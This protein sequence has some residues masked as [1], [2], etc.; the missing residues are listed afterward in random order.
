MTL[1]IKDLVF[2]TSNTTGTGTYNLAGPTTGFRSFAVCGNGAKVPYIASNSAGAYEIGIG[3]VSVGTPNLL[4]R[5]TILA[6]SNS[7]AAVNWGAA[8][9]IRLAPLAGINMVKDENLNFT[10][11]LGAAGGLANAHTVTLNPAPLAYSDGMMIAYRATIANTAAMTVN[12]NG[13]GAKALKVNGVDPV[14]GQIAIGTLIVGIYKAS[15]NTFE[16]INS[17]GVAYLPLSGGNLSGAIN[18]SISTI[19]SAATPDIWTG[20]GNVIN[21]TGAVTAT[22]F[23]NAPQ[24][25]ARRTLVCADACTFNNGANMIINGGAN[26]TA[27]AGDIVNVIAVTTTQFKL[28]PVKVDGKPVFYQTPMTLGTPINA[29]TGSPTSIDFTSIP[30]NAKRINLMLSG[31]STNGVSNPIIQIGDSGGIENTGYL[32]SGSIANGSPILFTTGFG[33]GGSAAAAN[34]LNGMI[35]LCLMNPTTNT[36]VAFGS[37]SGS[38]GGFVIVLSGSKSLSDMLDRVRLTTL[39][40]TDVFDAGTVNISYEL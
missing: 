15:N 27:T 17:P 31:L 10:D 9:N 28:E 1:T 39:N 4:A 19:A 40:G 26:Y 36:W 20:T 8:M 23:A 22:G 30:A 3:T 14:S 13:L 33:L 32:G 38:N 5:T 25:G 11:F 37:V 6:S 21:Y 34:I 35:T 29:A 16:A 12:V 24:A 2:E 18:E 7:D